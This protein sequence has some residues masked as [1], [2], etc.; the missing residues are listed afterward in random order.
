MKKGGIYIDSFATWIWIFRINQ[1]KNDVWNIAKKLRDDDDKNKAMRAI[2][3][4]THFVVV[5]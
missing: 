2:F 4:P 1:N 5:A 3:L